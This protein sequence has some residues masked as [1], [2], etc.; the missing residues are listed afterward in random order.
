MVP[1]ESGAAGRPITTAAILRLRQTQLVEA[2]DCFVVVR[3][4]RS[5]TSDHYDYLNRKGRFD[6]IG[7]CSAVRWNRTLYT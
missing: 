6:I 2:A 1:K 5:Q 3:R 4:L 7:C